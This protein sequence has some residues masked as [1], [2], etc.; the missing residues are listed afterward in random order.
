MG[1]RYMAMCISARCEHKW[2]TKFTPET[3]PEYQQCPK[4]W[5]YTVVL[6]R[7]WEEHLQHLREFISPEEAKKILKLYGFA[8][9]NGYMNNTK[10][11]DAKFT[12]LL[13]DLSNHH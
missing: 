8:K 2:F 5:K 6:V 13:K 11:R 1:K 10:S 7:Q 9:K 3:L 4:C 12:R